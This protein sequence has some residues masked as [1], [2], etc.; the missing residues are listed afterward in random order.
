MSFGRSRTGEGGNLGSLRA[1]NPDGSPGA[2]LI[3]QGR[4][5]ACAQITP[6]DVEDGLERDPQRRRDRLRV[7]AAMQEVENAGTCLSPSGGRAPTDDGCQ[8]AKLVFG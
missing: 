3:E 6:L 2:W 1:V 4:V 5:K 7:L 8:R